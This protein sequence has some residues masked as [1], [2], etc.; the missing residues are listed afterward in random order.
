MRKESCFLTIILLAVV[1]VA[2]AACGGAPTQPPTPEPTQIPPIAAPPTVEP[3]KALPTFTPTTVTETAVACDDSQENPF[4]WT[5]EAAISAGKTIFTDKC[6]ACH[7][8]DGKGVVPGAPDFSMMQDEIEAKGGEHFCSI[9]NGTM[10][11]MPAWGGKL[12]ANQMW[13]ALTYVTT[14]TK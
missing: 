6:Q 8:A 10:A 3:T 7:G 2:L 13:Q 1:V 4:P 12:T 11:G 9:Q 14:L 5:D